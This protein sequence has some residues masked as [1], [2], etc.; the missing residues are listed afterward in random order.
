V[1]AKELKTYWSFQYQK[2]FGKPYPVQKDKFIVEQMLLKKL[3]EKYDK[4]LILEA[5]D[6]VLSTKNPQFSTISL[7]ASSNFFS[8]YFRDLIRLSPILKYRRFMQAFPSDLKDRA[9]AL[10]DEYMDYSSSE[11]LND[12][13][14]VRKQEIPQLLEEMTKDFFK[15]M[16]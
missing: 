7:F 13:E 6:K 11:I 1:N 10:V 16:D 9:Y 4:Y 12:E 15:E 2:N 8:R 3:L 5:I 14:R